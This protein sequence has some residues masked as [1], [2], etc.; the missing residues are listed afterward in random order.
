MTRETIEELQG[1]ILEAKK[2]L[3]DH[4]NQALLTLQH[5]PLHFGLRLIGR[6]FWKPREQPARI[7]T[8][9]DQATA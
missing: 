6:C 9:A 7:E 8:F 1:N 4:E 5:R 2:E 3:A